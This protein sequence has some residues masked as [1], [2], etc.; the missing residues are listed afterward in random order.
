MTNKL[1]SANPKRKP[2]FKASEKAKMLGEDLRQFNMKKT[3]DTLVRTDKEVANRI[4]QII[5]LKEKNIKMTNQIIDIYEDAKG[6]IDK[7]GTDN[8]KLLVSKD[9]MAKAQKGI[10]EFQKMRVTIDKCLADEEAYVTKLLKDSQG[11]VDKYGVPQVVSYEDFE[12]NFDEGKKDW[13]KKE[14]M[15]MFDTDPTLIKLLSPYDVTEEDKSNSID[16]VLGYMPYVMELVGKYKGEGYQKVIR[17]LQALYDL[18]RLKK[19][20]KKKG[21]K[22][23]KAYHWELMDDLQ[24]YWDKKELPTCPTTKQ[25]FYVKTYFEH[26]AE[27]YDVHFKT[28]EKFAS[29]NDPKKTRPNS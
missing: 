24:C 21:K 26:L 11:K 14:C 3:F 22:Y 10:L 7:G 19:A 5:Y 28:I 15:K 4:D 18:G 23:F 12:K 8:V 17:S 16:Y 1:G 13:L 6:Y 27:K 2:K 25:P 9:V 29:D 20:S